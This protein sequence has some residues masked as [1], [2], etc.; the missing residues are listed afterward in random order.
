M[1]LSRLDNEVFFKKAF[2][3]KLVFTQF[4]KDVIGIDIKVGKI[5]TEK[6]F[7]PKIAYIDFSYDIFAESTD[8]RVI[9]EIQR[10]NYDYSFDRFLHYHLMAI[11]ELQ[12]NAK[13]YHIKPTVYTIVVL[14]ASDIVE[15]KDGETVSEEVLISDV[16]PHNLKGETFN[17]YGHQLIFINPNFKSDKTPPRIKDWLDLILESIDNPENPKINLKKRAIK[18]AAKLIED[19]N[20]T[21]E[22]RRAAKIAFA[23]EET[24]KIVERKAEA[25]GRKEANFEFAKKM[26][27]KGFDT[28]T[29]LEMTGLDVETINQLERGGR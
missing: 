9:I 10:V 11:A 21:P 13:D 24:R 29:I 6:H 18:K 15:D 27:A 8:H 12:L 5:E 4:V 14:T 26:I 1:H 3:D 16:N 23:T 2:T 7:K 28:E 19:D 20:L 17:F 22:E 25:K